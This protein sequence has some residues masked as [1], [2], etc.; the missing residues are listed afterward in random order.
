[1]VFRH[2]VLD[3]FAK[4]KEA[5]LASV[6]EAHAEQ[7]QK[8]ENHIRELQISHENLETELRRSQWSQA[9]CLREKDAFIEK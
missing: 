7:V 8:W 6:K 3:R 1:M 9:D 2:E 5:V 4:E